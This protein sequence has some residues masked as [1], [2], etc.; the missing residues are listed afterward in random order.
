[1]KAIIRK[2]EQAVSP[3]IATIL[4]VAITVVLAAVL[5]VMVSGL[6]SG[7]GAA[8]KSIGINVGKSS[9]G[10]NWILTFTS[11]PTGFGQNGTTLTLISGSGATLLAATPLYTLKTQTS[12]VQ[13]FPTTITGAPVSVGDRI[14]AAFGSGASQY[15]AGV[16][17]Q[18]ASS[19]SILAS[20]TL[21]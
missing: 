14:L 17:Y 19:G 12:G 7:P 10:S 15:P 4:M 2:D 16:Q 3:V 18:I 21:S 11:V 20:G 6:I 9:D 8:P 1:M 13:Y 5:Y